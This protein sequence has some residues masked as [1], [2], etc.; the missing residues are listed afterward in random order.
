[1]STLPDPA[2]PATAVVE[3]EPSRHPTKAE[4]L[5]ALEAEIADQHAAAAAKQAARGKRGARERVLA[6][7][8]PDTFQ[9][10]DPFVRE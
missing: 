5:A 2:S 9:E 7:L 4:H 3:P 1:M 6:L 10:L 8:D